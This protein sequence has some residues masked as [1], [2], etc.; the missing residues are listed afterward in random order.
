MLPPMRTSRTGGDEIRRAATRTRSPADFLDKRAHPRA[1]P[2]SA[3]CRSITRRQAELAVANT[4]NS[5]KD[6]RCGGGTRIV[7]DAVV[8]A[9]GR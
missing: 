4:S 6:V 1:E 9:G 3:R 2:A 7:A 5:A 8:S